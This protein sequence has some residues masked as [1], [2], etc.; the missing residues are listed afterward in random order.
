MK[1]AFQYL[2]LFTL[3]MLPLLSACK[4]SSRV[5]ASGKNSSSL[6]KN[7]PEV[8]QALEELVVATHN[9]AAGYKVPSFLDRPE[10]ENL[11]PEDKVKLQN[12]QEGLANLNA[13]LSKLGAEELSELFKDPAF[14]DLKETVRGAVKEAQGKGA[15]DS[16]EEELAE[17]EE[18]SEEDTKNLI[19]KF[20]SIFHADDEEDGY[21]KLSIAGAAAYGTLAAWNLFTGAYLDP[22][23]AKDVALDRPAF[24][25]V[26]K[27]RAVV[28]IMVFAGFAAL[29]GLGL[30]GTLTE[31]QF[32][33]MEGSILLFDGLSLSLV[34]VWGLL[35]TYRGDTNSRIG[36]ALDSTFGAPGRS[37]VGGLTDL[38][39]DPNKV[40]K[41]FT[42]KDW[43]Q[44]YRTVLEP[45]RGL[46]TEYKE[47][48]DEH[49]KWIQG[50]KKTKEPLPG[51]SSQNQKQLL[52][53]FKQW[54]VIKKSIKG[55]ELVKGQEI[56]RIYNSSTNMDEKT[57]I[58][59]VERFIEDYNALAEKN[60]KLSKGSR[61]TYKINPST[62][63]GN[64]ITKQNITPKQKFSNPYKTNIAGKSF[65]NVTLTRV[66]MAALI[67][68]GAFELLQGSKLF[69]DTY[70][71]DKEG[72]KL[73]ESSAT[74]EKPTLYHFMVKLEKLFRLHDQMYPQS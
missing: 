60:A 11:T 23:K 25:K 44:Y 39:M 24:S 46:E 34:G 10:Y 64:I 13:Q 28:D 71:K 50:G 66:G 6:E 26:V 18:E 29:T 74:S 9:M 69:Y 72:L 32:N 73:T 16:E 4:T 45:P 43:V 57:K 55:E 65:D 36:R 5:K 31:D 58:K 49:D 35:E 1:K 30:S 62:I 15:E 41:P 8:N 20:L 67:G 22:A 68:F 54:E 52:T 2:R 21:I 40:K 3:I 27:S 61:E 70:G 53:E 63:E 33:T 37:R 48:K 59:A 38:T 14:Q 17:D 42:P 12:I 51:R 19:E 56:L 7:P 47:W